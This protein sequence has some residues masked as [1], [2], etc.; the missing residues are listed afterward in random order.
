M[1]PVLRCRGW[2]RSA[3][4][5]FAVLA[6]LFF[7]DCAVIGLSPD[8]SALAAQSKTSTA[9]EN[10]GNYV[11]KLLERFKPK[12]KKK[13]AKKPKGTIAKRKSAPAKREATAA[14]REATAAKRETTAAK[15]EATA[16]KSEAAVA[17]RE[18]TTDKREAKVATPG[19]TAVRVPPPVLR[20]PLPGPL[21]PDAPPSTAVAA[22]ESLTAEDRVIEV[23]QTGR[24]AAVEPPTLEPTATEPAPPE[25]P[26]DE[27]PEFEPPGLEPSIVEPM[28]PVSP[29]KEFAAVEP[30]A[31]EPP[32][33]EPTTPELPAAE[34]PAIEPAATEPTTDGVPETDDPRSR[35]RAF[36]EEAA[37]VVVPRPRPALPQG[38]EQPSSPKASNNGKWPAED[39][40]LARL[41]CE[42]EL[43]GLD[44][45]W[46]EAAP[47]GGPRGC[48]VAAPISLRYAGSVKLT[49]PAVLNCRTAAAFHRWIVTV[50]QPAAERDFTE[51]VTG[52][53]VAASYDCRYRYNAAGGKISE[54]ARANAIDISAFTLASGKKVQVQGGWQAK[55]VSL[56]GSARFLREVHKGGCSVFSTV[57][58]PEANA[59]HASHFHFDLQARNRR[60]KL[61]E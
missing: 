50:V 6:V 1:K 13:A 36:G 20:S 34:P 17:K 25:P 38:G 61:C 26:T 28:A 22:P 4:R 47:I 39:V 16:A 18:T 55:L 49:P 54:H 44:V 14:K 21:P 43:S 59:A 46:D 32:T 10:V 9:V 51:R 35:K 33:A 56:N 45:A 12:S 2:L 7:L 29:T 23:P 19:A 3:T 30:P 57:L 15:R 5:G 42:V 41:A 58:G 27:P 60:F 52:L 11:N 48:G 31:L 53:S 8:S 37:L 24:Q 40:R